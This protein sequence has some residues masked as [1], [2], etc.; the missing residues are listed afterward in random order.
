MDGVRKNKMETINVVKREPPNKMD[1]NH[2]DKDTMCNLWKDD[3]GSKTPEKILSELPQE[4]DKSEV[5]GLP[6]EETNDGIGTGTT[7]TKDERV[8]NLYHDFFETE[9]DI[10]WFIRMNLE[11]SA[12]PRHSQIFLLK[13][14]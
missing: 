8:K 10:L 1:G 5:I 3:N 14:N 2:Y 9:E 4:K 11:Q 13:S 7:G 6:E 12:Y